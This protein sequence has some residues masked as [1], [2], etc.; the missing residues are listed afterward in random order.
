MFLGIG[1]KGSFCCANPKSEKANNKD[2][3]L[4]FIVVVFVWL[5]LNKKTAHCCTVLNYLF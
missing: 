2:K 4:K 3:I 1:I 5:N